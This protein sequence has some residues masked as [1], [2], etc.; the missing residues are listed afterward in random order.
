MEEQRKIIE[1]VMRRQ[2]YAAEEAE[3]AYHLGQAENLLAD[4][5]QRTIE[6]DAGPF[7]RNTM[8]I[9]RA[10]QMEPHFRALFALLDRRV[11]KRQYP[12][13]WWRPGDPR[14]ESLPD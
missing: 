5:Y 12:E 8:D 11:L 2:G 10:S 9:F 4:L 7:S 6:S 1:G 3:I 13:S 14:G